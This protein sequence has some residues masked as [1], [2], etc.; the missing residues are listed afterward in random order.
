MLPQPRLLLAL[1]AQPPESPKPPECPLRPLKEPDF[2]AAL[3]SCWAHEFDAEVDA[4]VRW[5]LKL[6][7]VCLFT[8]PV[9]TFTVFPLTFLLTVLVL[10]W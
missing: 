6:C 3:L 8:L 2:P 7:A 9:L 1:E 10:L 5:E 4:E